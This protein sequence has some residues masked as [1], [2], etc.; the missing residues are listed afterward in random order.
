VTRLRARDG[1][2][3]SELG[4]SRSSGCQ[5]TAA[6]P[7]PFHLID[8]KAQICAKLMSRPVGDRVVLTPDPW[9]PARR[10]PCND[11]ELLIL[12]D[13]IRDESEEE[14]GETD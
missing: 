12:A 13:E 4:E 7:C 11:C 5:F 3:F 8:Q 10:R 9:A 6:I 1:V 2:R 14:S